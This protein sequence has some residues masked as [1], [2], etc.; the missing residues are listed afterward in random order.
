[1]EVVVGVEVVEVV[2]D[3]E[4]VVGFVV[5][6]TVVVFLEVV[7]VVV[8]GAAVVVRAHTVVPNF[9]PS[10][11]SNIRSFG[12]SASLSLSQAAPQRVTLNAFA[13]SNM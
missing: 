3:V 2:V 10:V 13:C 4:V 8:V 11:P 12:I 9:A 6:I 7:D 5:L 1:M